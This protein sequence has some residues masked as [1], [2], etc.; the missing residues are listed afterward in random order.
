M[1][2]LSREAVETKVRG[3]KGGSIVSV[4]YYSYVDLKACYKGQLSIIKVTSKLCRVGI[5]YNNMEEVRVWKETHPTEHRD[6]SSWEHSDDGRIVY[7]PKTGNTLVE[8]YKLNQNENVKSFYIIIKDGTMKIVKTLD[9]YKEY[10]RPSYFSTPKSDR[11]ERP[12]QKINI[13]HF[14]K[15]GDLVVDGMG[16]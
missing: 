2:S 15:I 14:L 5:D 13:D 10:V 8:I 7:V 11:P 9:E 6:Y 12:T 1:K 16:V 4:A 3:I